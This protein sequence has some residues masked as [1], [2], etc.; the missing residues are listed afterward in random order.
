MRNWIFFKYHHPGRPKITAKPS[1]VIQVQKEEKIFKIVLPLPLQSIKVNFLR[2]NVN[3]G[4]KSK[5]GKE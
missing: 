3:P 2:V 4:A 1:W 5:S